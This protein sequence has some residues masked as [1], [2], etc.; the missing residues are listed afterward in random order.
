MCEKSNADYSKVIEAFV[1]R[2]H[3]N[4]DYLDCNDN[5][6]GYAGPCLPKDV[7]AMIHF[8][9]KL[10]INAGIFE[11]LDKENNNFKPT[12]LADMRKE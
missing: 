10:N 6:R 4:K 8:C 2:D 11:F 3:V 1:K 7:Q 9:K 12:V 5:L